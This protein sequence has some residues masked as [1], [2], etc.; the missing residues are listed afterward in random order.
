MHSEDE[1]KYLKQSEFKIVGNGLQD[2]EVRLSCTNPLARNGGNVNYEG[3][4]MQMLAKN[5]V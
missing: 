1:V 4:D 3:V 5:V 2:M